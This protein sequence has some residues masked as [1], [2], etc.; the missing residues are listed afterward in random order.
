MVFWAGTATCD[1]HV[2]ILWRESG[3]LD[4]CALSG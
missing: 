1:S 2:K 4:R 3:G